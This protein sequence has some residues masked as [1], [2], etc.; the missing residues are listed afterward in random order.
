[1]D[2]DDLDTIASADAGV[3]MELR[4][5]GTD[6]VLLQADGVTPVTLTLL[7][8]D[9]KAYKHAERRAADRRMARQAERGGRVALTSAALEEDQLNRLVATTTDWSGIRWGGVDQPFNADNVRAMYKTWPWA[10]EQAV[11]FQEKRAN[12]LKTQPAT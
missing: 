9:S 10:L 8:Q 7:G 3:K 12:F 5:P 6:E 11:A 4:H 2:L 1:M